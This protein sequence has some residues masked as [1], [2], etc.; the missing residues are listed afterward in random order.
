MN[1]DGK[2]SREKLLTDGWI[3]HR[4]GPTYLIQPTCVFQ[5]KERSRPEITQQTAERH[6]TPSKSWQRNK[7][8]KPTDLPNPCPPYTNPE[9]SNLREGYYSMKKKFSTT[10][11]DDYGS[12]TNLRK[13]SNGVTVVFIFYR[14]LNFMNGSY[15]ALLRDVEAFAALQRCRPYYP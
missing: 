7:I 6:K 1:T 2:K 11:N 15:H 13:R 10:P 14:V 9:N 8:Q 12:V 3:Y 5:Q 4:G